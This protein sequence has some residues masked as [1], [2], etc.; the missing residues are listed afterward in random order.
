MPMG[1]TKR[2]NEYEY[3]ADTRSDQGHLD[4]VHDRW[5]DTAQQLKRHDKCCFESRA[6]H[7]QEAHE[8][9]EWLQD[10]PPASLAVMTISCRNGLSKASL[11]KLPSDGN[12]RV[13]V[14]RGLIRP[15]N[16]IYNVLHCN[17]GGT[18]GA[19]NDRKIVMPNWGRIRTKFMSGAFQQTHALKTPKTVSKVRMDAARTEK[20]LTATVPRTRKPE[21]SNC[22]PPMAT[23]ARAK[24]KRRTAKVA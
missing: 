1:S 3:Q 14:R 11:S 4:H 15:D 20:L 21:A 18:N 13:R 17:G 9:A 19:H 5:H 12:K 24:P 23:C 7:G 8:H 2:A 22:K 16:R 10:T 6:E